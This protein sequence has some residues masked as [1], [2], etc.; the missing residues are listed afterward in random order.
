MS[1]VRTGLAKTK[2]VT[3]YRVA[4]KSLKRGLL[5]FQRVLIEA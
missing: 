3:P 4:V 1:P 2:H 5:V